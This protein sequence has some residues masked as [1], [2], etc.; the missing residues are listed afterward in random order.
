MRI[1]SVFNRGMR[2]TCKTVTQTTLVG[3]KQGIPEQEGSTTI[4]DKGPLH[5]Y[6][7][8]KSQASH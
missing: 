2:D 1:E 7:E 6:Y 8:Y 3:V 5:G 4:K